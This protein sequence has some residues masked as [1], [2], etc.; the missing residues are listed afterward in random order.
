MERAAQLRP[1]T[2]VQ[3]SDSNKQVL[4]TGRV[5]FISPTTEGESQTVLIKV[6]VPNQSGNLRDGQFVSSR[7]LWGQRQNQA[8]V[9]ASAIAR[10]GKDQFV[11]VVQRNGEE[12]IAKKQVVEVGR[13]QGDFVEVLSGI[14]PGMSVVSAGLQRLQD[15]LRGFCHFLV[16]PLA[17]N[18]VHIPRGFVVGTMSSV[19]EMLGEGGVILT[20]FR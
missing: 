20:E 15:G 4:G 5:S 18:L 8:V 7:V 1:G 19:D 14:Q 13:Q 11:Y 3:I 2:P 16:Y 12:L 9:P 6:G 17:N 10:Q